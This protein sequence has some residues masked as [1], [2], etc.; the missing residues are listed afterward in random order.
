MLRWS[1]EL[2]LTTMR[3]SSELGSVPYV[4]SGMGTWLGLFDNHNTFPT[5]TFPLSHLF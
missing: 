4:L 2:H 5:I 3:Y 1:S